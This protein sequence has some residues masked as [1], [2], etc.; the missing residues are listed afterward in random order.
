MYSTCLAVSVSERA[1]NLQAI[2]EASYYFISTTANSIQWPSS[3]LGTIQKVTIFFYNSPRPLHQ[4][5]QAKPTLCVCLLE[6]IASFIYRPLALFSQWIPGLNAISQETLPMCSSVIPHCL[7]A[8]SSTEREGEKK[9]KK[10]QHCQ[11]SHKNSQTLVCY[12][13]KLWMCFNPFQPGRKRKG[14]GRWCAV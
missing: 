13:E 1:V 12:T 6:K 9:K 10:T 14:G 4:W 5:K 7:Q 2:W 8:E 11:P 3:P